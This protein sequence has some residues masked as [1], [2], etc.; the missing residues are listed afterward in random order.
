MLD[1]Q[2]CVDVFLGLETDPEIV[3]FADVNVDGTVDVLD[4]QAIVN[5]YLQG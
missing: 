5:A 4:V 2:L 1:V 3:A